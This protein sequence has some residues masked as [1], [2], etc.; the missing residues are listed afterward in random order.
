MLFRSDV[1]ELDGLR[2]AGL[3]RIEIAEVVGLALN[4]LFF[5]RLATLVA[6][7]PYQMEQ[8][9]DRWWVQMLRPLLA[10]KFRR[11]RQ[12]VDET[13]LR[14]DE[15]SGPGAAIVNALDGLPL[16]RDL[17]RVLDGIWDDTPLAPRTV[18]LIFAVVA[19]AMG[20]EHCVNEAR[21]LI[22]PGELD[23][24]DI[25]HILA[26]L[27]SPK[28]TAVERVL[29]P[30]ARETVWYKPAQLQRRCMEVQQ[31]VRHDEFL[32]FIGVVSLV[33][34]LCRCA[35]LAAATE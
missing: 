11:M 20:S 22:D 32:H 12:L 21:G 31:Q 25:D 1:A 2:Q 30:F 34:A 4:H 8:F 17:R 18:S 23:D 14:E 19:H 6:L 3:S 24:N 5:N 33:N 10:I 27:T 28:L 13:A 16:A 9:P 35:F 7:P 29:I 15:K 26:H